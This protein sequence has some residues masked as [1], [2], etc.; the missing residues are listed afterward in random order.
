MRAT[1]TCDRVNRLDF[2]QQDGYPPKPYP[3]NNVNAISLNDLLKANP[4]NKKN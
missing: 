4:N 2:F 3:E 1:H